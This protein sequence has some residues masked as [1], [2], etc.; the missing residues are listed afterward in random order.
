MI[1][2][3][4]N[5][6]LAL[7]L[8]GHSHHQVAKEWM[9]QQSEPNSIFFCRATQQSYLRLLTN[10]QLLRAYGND[11]LT[12]ETAWQCYMDLLADFR[13]ALAMEPSGLE[14]WWTRYALRDSASPKLW[15]DAY[16][17]AFAKAAGYTLVTLDHGFQQFD[18][19]SL[20][21]LTT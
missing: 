20:S 4:S 13:I 6:W 5:M 8:S 14:S 1:L 2:C 11:A 19:L 16:L 17:A 3:D 7:S 21:L 12:N 18:G 15:M 10:P 9:E